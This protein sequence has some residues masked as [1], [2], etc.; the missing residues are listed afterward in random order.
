MP[1]ADDRSREDIREAYDELA[2]LRH[3]NAQVQRTIDHSKQ[4][5]AQCWE[6]IRAIEKRTR[7]REA[8]F[9]DAI[10]NKDVPPAKDV[11]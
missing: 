3:A 1:S 8:P 2:R 10:E 7:S 6:T 9:S 11:P 4:L 5:I